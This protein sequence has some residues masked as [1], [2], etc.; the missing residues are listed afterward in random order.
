MSNYKDLLVWQR[1]I[2]L[3]TMVYKAT[4][5]FPKEETYSLTSQIRRAAI[6]IP[7]NIAEGSARGTTKNFIYFL[8]VAIGSLRELETQLII[9]INLDY[10]QQDEFDEIKEPLHEVA[11]MLSGLKRSL[12]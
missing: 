6:S 4:S 11:K 5:Y 9:A 7:S 10:L 2:E 12:R 1:A 3:V 8:N